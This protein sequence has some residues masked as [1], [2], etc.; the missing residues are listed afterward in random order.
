MGGLKRLEYRGYDS[1]GIGIDGPD[2][3][4]F[5][6]VHNG[7]ITNYKDIKMFLESKG[8]QFE[9]ETDTECI[10]KL[11]KHIRSQNPSYTFRQLVEQT[12]S[13]LEGAFAC[14][15]KSIFYPGEC[16][17]TRRGSPLLVGIKAEGLESDSIP[18]QYSQ[19][20]HPKTYAHIPADLDPTSSPLIPRKKT[21][22]MFR[23]ESDHTEE[24]HPSDGDAVEY[25]FA[26]DASAIIEHTNRVIFLEDDDVAAVSNG[27]LSI[28]RVKRGTDG[29][30]QIARDITS[31]QMEIEQIMKGDYSTFMQK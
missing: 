22:A 25:F 5:V 24:I 29:G 4:E 23:V 17:A 7:I 28:H 1:A 27:V 16:V 13:Q 31:L 12:I 19:E 10:A 14:V 8:Y 21:S 6:V 9:S 2:G 20:D 15:F 30:T 18:V 3:N 11:V 26:S